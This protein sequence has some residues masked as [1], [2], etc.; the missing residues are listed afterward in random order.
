MI[1]KYKIAALCVSRIYDDTTHEIVTELNKNITEKGYRLFVYHTCSDL[2]W[3][4]A[5]ERGEASVFSLIDMRAIDVLIIVDEMIKN[6]NITHKLIDRAALFDVPVIMI[7]GSYEGVINITF[8][9]ESGFEDVVRHIVEFH[10]LKR[11]HFMAGIQGNEFSESRIDVFARVLEENGIPFDRSSMVSYGDFW[12]TPTA[13]ATE[14]LLERGELPEAIVCANDTMA[15][16]VC[17]TLTNAGVRIPEEVVVTGFDGIMDINFSSPRITTCLCCYGDITQRIAG[18]LTLGKEELLREAHYFIKPRLVLNES[19][20][21]H[22]GGI[23]N[24]SKYVS[25]LNSRF[26]RYKEDEKTLNEIGVRIISGSTLQSAANELYSPIIYN[27]RCMLRKEVI[28]E[29]IDPVEKDIPHDFGEELCVFFDTDASYPFLPHFIPAKSVIPGLDVI[30]DMGYP[31]IFTALSFLDIPL[32]YVAFTYQNYDIQNYEKIAQTVNALNNSIGAFRNL[33]YQQYITKQVQKLSQYDQL[34]GLYT[35]GGCTRA[36]EALV[37][38]LKE[39]NR[40]ITAVMV[41]LDGL[42]H[43]NDNYGHNEGDYAIKAMATA[44]KNSCPDNAVC[45]RMGGDEMAAFLS[46][47]ASLEDIKEEIEA[48]LRSVNRTSGKPYKVAASIGLFRSADRQNLPSFEDLIRMSDEQMYAEKAEHRRL[49][50]EKK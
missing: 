11:L 48:R 28:D 33:R 43:I 15:I 35:R 23:I 14:K 32:G 13:A 18:L 22:G 31:V 7:G 24:A 46:S 49:R 39:Q 37:S 16:T 34:T 1:G 19:C 41:D 27:M 9:F 4:S 3:D 36:Y 44:L 12:A 20:G 30:M 47:S 40:P 25:D 50:E 45:I 8:D 42:K 5:S 6:K 21:C 10:G 26:Y 38:R 17:S 2:Y 29:T